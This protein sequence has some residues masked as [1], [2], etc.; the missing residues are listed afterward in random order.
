MHPDKIRTAN[1]PR[2][3]LAPKDVIVLTSLVGGT[4][5]LIGFIIGLAY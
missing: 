3:Q 2:F 4:A 5:Y 1:L